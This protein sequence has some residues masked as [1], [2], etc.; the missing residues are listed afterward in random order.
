[1]V[2]MGS[3][4]PD[5][6]LIGFDISLL[7]F[8]PLC[9]PTMSV[10]TF[11]ASLLDGLSG[12]NSSS[13]ISAPRSSPSTSARQADIPKQS[14]IVEPT[15]NAKI[16]L[17]EAEVL[18]LNYDIP[19][20]EIRTDS[21]S[22]PSA[23]DELDGANICDHCMP[24]IPSSDDVDLFIDLGIDFGTG[25]TKVCFRDSDSNETS[26][27]TFD[28]GSVKL[29]QA[30]ISSKIAILEDDLILTGLTSYEWKISP[31]PVKVN[32]DFI[33]MRL[34]YLDLPRDNSQW[35]PSIDLLDSPTTIE[36]LSAYFLSRVI[37]RSR[38]WIQTHYPELFKNRKVGW[39]L[40]VGA[41]VEYW[42]GPAIDRFKYVLKL[43]WALS[44]SPISEKG[45]MLTL[46]QLNE[47]MKYT[48]EWIKENPE[49]DCFAKPEIAA[50][51][52]AHIRA[53]G[54]QEGFFVFFDVGEGTTEGASFRFHRDRGENEI[55][56]YSGF[57]RPLGVA[58]LS[59]QLEDELDLDQS[60]IQKALKHWH[61]SDSDTSR[62]LGSQRRKYFQQAVARVIVKGFKDYRVTCPYLWRGEINSILPTFLGGGGS[63]LQF[64][65]HGIESTYLDF[66]HDRSIPDLPPY[67]TTNVPIP[68]DLELRGLS[69]ADFNRFSVAY[70]LSIEEG[71]FPE[72]NFPSDDDFPKPRPR[73]D[74]TDHGDMKDV[75]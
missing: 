47:C 8:L 20:S 65:K 68:S 49:L 69:S 53:I 27:A 19:Q 60:S 55:I 46:P 18:K 33:K 30:L 63:R 70:G 38:H 11:L 50:A 21:E 48:R 12:N 26:I 61:L 28:Y 42:H 4:A 36:N 9:E 14:L 25:Y 67:Q 29:E 5:C 66:G 54:S 51:V 64:F 44:F 56:F 45:K 35:P 75:T 24:A 59:Q 2:V 3:N 17:P 7:N 58:T 37:V 71:K 72:F 31:W 1:M 6:Q 62:I 13:S 15:I 41:P 73:N 22:A 39:I 74:R 57:V 23:I 10:W 16:D 40:N 52:W 32:I 34:A 43:A